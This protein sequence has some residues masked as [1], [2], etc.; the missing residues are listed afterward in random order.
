VSAVRARLSGERWHLSHGPIDLIVAA[1][2]DP[3]ACEMAHECCWT[4]FLPILETLVAELPL[5]RAPL[6]SC[7]VLPE[8]RGPVAARMVVACAPFANQYITPMAA[9]AGAVADE[10]IGCFSDPAICRASINNGGD[11][12]LMLLGD[13]R[14]T[15]G[16]AADD[17]DVAEQFVIHA[18][19]P[20]RGVATS[21]WRGR[22]LSLGIADRVTVV[23]RSAAIADAAATMIANAVNVEHPAIIR[24]PAHCLQDDSD[25]GGLLAT[26]AVP[27][28]PGE[29][30]SAA[31]DEGQDF[32]EALLRSGIIG[33][34]VLHLQGATR[35]VQWSPEVSGTP[36]LLRPPRRASS[37][38]LSAP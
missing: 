24:K 11:I 37:T 18:R 32:A 4:R 38:C 29:V 26:V 2:G 7:G 14:Y 27:R 33:A 9:V 28:L 19:D 21:G 10:L 30:V 20:I 16:V 36:A 34:A 8:A 35:L 15:V 1:T 22:S 25:L 3:R 17:V 31:L 12:A 5:L 6:D 23:A 13:A